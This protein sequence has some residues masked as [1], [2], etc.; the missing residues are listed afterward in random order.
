MAFLGIDIGTSGC[1]VCA[2]D[3]SGNMLSSASRKYQ[4]IRGNNTREIE[5]DVIREHVFASLSEAA[6]ACPEP[7]QAIAVTCLGESLVCLDE[8]ETVLCNSMVTGDHRGADGVEKVCRELGADYVF[9]VTGLMPSQLYSLPKL[10]HLQENTEVLRTVKKL[11]FYEDYIGYLLTG[12]RKVSYSSAARS[13]ALDIHSL[14]WDKKLL[15]TAGLTPEHFSEPVPSGT[16][17]GYVKPEIAEKCHLTGKIPVVA[18]GHDQATAALG[19]GFMDTTLGEDCIGTCECLALML[20]ETYDQ[21]V[22]QKLQMP[23]MLYLLPNTCFTTFEVTTCGALM[24]W[25]QDVLL[26]GTKE[27]CERE[28]LNFFRY[29]DERVAGKH[30]DVLILPQFGSSGHPDLNLNHMAGTITGLTLD[31]TE[32][33]LYLALKESMIFQIRLAHEAASPLGIDFQKL[34]TAGGASNSTVTSQLR[35][36]IFQKPVYTLANS[37]AGTLGCM[38]L[39]AV[40]IGEYPD[41]V[42]CTKEVVRYFKETLPNPENFRHY[43]EKYQLYKRLYDKMHQL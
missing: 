35:A 8:S 24:N 20:P 18:G 39:A 27:M 1:K 19:S 23:C 42:T 12:E 11:F 38:I 41:I 7:V 34:V 32:E 30:T 40:A 29:M 17:I 43:E 2:Y 36:D 4:E 28:G 5:P 21:A 16:I 3:H 22:L 13:M 26:K 31:T 10:I 25:G 9:Q 14:K 37:E 33:D 6:A 15:A